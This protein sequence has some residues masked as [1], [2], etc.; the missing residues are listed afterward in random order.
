MMPRYDFNSLGG[1]EMNTD[2]LHRQLYATDASVYRILPEG[3]CFPKN[4][5]DIVS[6]VNFA[7]ENKIPLIP[8]AGGT[9]LAGQVVGSGLIVDVSKYFNNILDFDAKAKT[10]TVEPGV[11]RHDLNAFLAPHQLFFGPNTSTSN[12]CTIGGMVGNNSSGTTSIKYG[13]TR[14][15]IQ[16]VECVLYDGSLVLF[17]AKEMEECFKKG[18]KSDLEHQIYQFFTEILSDPDHQ[19]SIRTEYPKATVHRRNTGYALDA[20]L[21][22]FTDHKV[23]MLNLA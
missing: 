1:I 4:K 13:V 19:K 8:R 10:V 22:H 16:S 18:S 6:L 14:D 3:V 15:K 9:S 23:P 7:R 11:V 5:L 2:S 12:R 17:E 21:N 20:L